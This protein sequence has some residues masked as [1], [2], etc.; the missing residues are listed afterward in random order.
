[1]AQIQRARRLYVRERHPD[2]GG[3]P[4]GFAAGLAEFDRR[5]AEL[6]HP[7]E[8]AARVTGTQRPRGLARLV[9]GLSGR[10]QGRHAPPRVR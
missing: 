8:P 7:Q 2:V 4:D 5:L 3:E 6:E 10:I 1:V 9:A